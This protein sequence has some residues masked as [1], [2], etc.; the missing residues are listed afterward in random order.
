M[1]FRGHIIQPIKHYMITLR[2]GGLYTLMQNLQ[3]RNTQQQKGF[4]N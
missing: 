3:S 2:L 1:T 4:I